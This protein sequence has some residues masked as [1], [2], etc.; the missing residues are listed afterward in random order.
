MKLFIGF[1]ILLACLVVQAQDSSYSY[2]GWG[3]PG[4]AQSVPLKVLKDTSFTLVI[5]KGENPVLIKRFDKQHALHEHIENEYD[6]RGNHRS[7]KRFDA[8][9]R[10]REE[11]IFQNDP[12]EMAL[13]RTIFGNTFVPA[14]SN[15]MIRREYNEFERETGYFIVGVMGRTLASRVTL[16]REDRRKDREILRDDLAGKVL[17]E[18]RYKYV[19]A[20]NRTVLEE[21]DGSGK[22]LQR[23][24]LFDHHDIIQK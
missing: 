8:M 2:A 18:R 1:I 14:N 5:L 23:V 22:M 7:S 21:Y 10:L 17:I 3:K 6:E 16:Y 24:V 11:S 15:F 4:S 13:F 12:T 20:E 9:G 19:D